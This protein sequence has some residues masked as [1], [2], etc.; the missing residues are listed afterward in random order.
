M[1]K[2]CL[3][4]VYELAKKDSR[5]IF[6]GSDLGTKTLQNLKEERPDQFL[7]EGISEGHIIGMA[8]GMAL[9]G[10]VVYVNTIAP[11]L[12]RRAYEQIVIDLALHRAN[13]RL[14]GNGGGLVYAPLGPT[15]QTLEDFATMR[16]IPNMTVVAPADAN[17]MKS[18]M[19]RSLDYEGPIYIRV[20]KGGD[21]IVTPADRQFHIGRHVLSRKGDHPITFFTT[22]VALQRTLVAADSLKKQGWSVSVI[23]LPTIKPLDHAAI[24]ET[25][26]KSEIVMSIEEHNKYGGLGS[27]IC[28]IFMEAN[29]KKHV[30][31]RMIAIPD[32]FSEKYGSQEMLLDEYGLSSL[33]IENQF[34]D[35]LKT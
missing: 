3:E 30:K 23:H 33:S 20:A 5:V 35:L 6:V 18:F 9:D 25:L 19:L 24:R 21:Q 7:M 27:A 13:V 8:A 14:I 11:F 15:H 32:R 2:A 31:F 28:E 34:K 26:L 4:M 17:E 12:V 22:G 16:A 10:R 1:R 29:L